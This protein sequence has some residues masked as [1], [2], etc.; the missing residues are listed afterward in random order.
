M[1]TTSK[2]DAA[3]G[4]AYTFLDCMNALAQRFPTNT[5]L[6]DRRDMLNL[7]ISDD[8][9]HVLMIDRW[10]LDMAVNSITHTQRPQNLSLAIQA[11]D[12]DTVLSED[13]DVLTSI[14][15]RDMY[16]AMAPE[17]RDVL[18]RYLCDLCDAA[19]AYASCA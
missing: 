5:E 19:N 9:I 1:T 15:A 17:E 18:Q 2:S 14:G 12:L 11:G 8:T 4:F 13:I 10:I 3:K 16:G 7:L 6:T